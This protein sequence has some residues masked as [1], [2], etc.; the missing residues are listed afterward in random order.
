MPSYESKIW[1]ICKL[2]THL[3]ENN[4]KSRRRG[5]DLGFDC[6]I[7]AAN[8]SARR[9]EPGRRRTMD[10]KEDWWPKVNMG[11]VVDLEGGVVAEAFRKRCKDR[12]EKL[13][14][15]PPYT[16]HTLFLPYTARPTPCTHTPHTLRPTHIHP[17][18]KPFTP[19]YALSPHTVRP[20]PYTHTPH[21]LRHTP[22]TPSYA[23]PST[24]PTPYALHS[25]ALRGWSGNAFESKPQQHLVSANLP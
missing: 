1:I 3:S 15:P 4:G 21:T 20:T 7:S 8:L 6:I 5:V 24:H 16:L 22:Y 19:P 23:L 9:P 2:Q 17:T 12:V 18:P 25:S 13:L 11:T 14:T 10:P